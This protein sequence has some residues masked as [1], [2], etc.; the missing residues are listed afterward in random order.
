M[1]KE[2]KIK[3]IANEIADSFFKSDN[4]TYNDIAWTIACLVY[5]VDDYNHKE[6]NTKNGAI[7]KYIYN[8]IGSVYNFK[9]EN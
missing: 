9:K 6:F 8:L 2:E 5:I 7:A 1:E 3:D 4:Y